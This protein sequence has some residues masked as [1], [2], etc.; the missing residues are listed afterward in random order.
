MEEAYLHNETINLQRERNELARRGFSPEAIKSWFEE[1]YRMY[2]REKG[3]FAC[4][5]CKERVVMVLFHDKAIFRHYNAEACA[6]ERNY[7]KYTAGREQDYEKARKQ[8]A[9]KALIFEALME[10]DQGYYSVQEG[11]LFKKEL[12]FVPD[13]LISF[14]NGEQWT[15]DY[16]VNLRGDA[17]FRKN[18]E[19]RL[20]SYKVNGFKSLFLL[21]QDF[22][23][24]QKERN[25]SFNH[26][27]L[28]IAVP[29]NEANISW[30]TFITSEQPDPELYRRYFQTTAV[31]V[32]SILYFD[33]SRSIVVLTRFLQHQDKW[34]ELLFPP[35]EMPLHELFLLNEKHL[36][37]TGR[38]SF[39]FYA[40]DEGDLMRP[41]MDGLQKR[42]IQHDQDLQHQR[43]RE[44][45]RNPRRSV[46]NR[47][48]QADIGQLHALL[49]KCLSSP[50]R[51]LYPSLED[52]LQKAASYIK[53]YEQGGDHAEQL[54]RSA[55]SILMN[56]SHPLLGE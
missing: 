35:C 34:G 53:L 48:I 13:F 19:L 7:A 9:A 15:V 25:I 11:Y 27:E 43:E 46:L 51:S 42:L 54:Y 39:R 56:I 16:L 14:P 4:G 52:N 26:C 31:K 18:V 32:N 22:L 40:Q 24:I 50:K 38:F 17:A 36:I 47:P 21:D 41:Y 2:S 33:V 5:C 10:A 44:F 55:Y 8:T 30:E 6:G 29:P 3:A 12:S 28:S 49:D 45:R 37:A 1:K 23:T 20:R